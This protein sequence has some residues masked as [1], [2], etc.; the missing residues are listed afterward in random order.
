MTLVLAVCG[1][2]LLF[3][4]FVSF[5]L[6]L[7]AVCIVYYKIAPDEFSELYKYVHHLSFREN[8]FVTMVWVAI[9]S[10]MLSSYIYF[11]EIVNEPPAITCMWGL[12]FVFVFLTFMS[13]AEWLLRDRLAATSSVWNKT[14]KTW[15]Y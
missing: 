5:V 1:V 11:A 15:R 7:S 8:G 6:G 2:L 12:L 4:G 9:L 3:G 14:K 10:L 13:L